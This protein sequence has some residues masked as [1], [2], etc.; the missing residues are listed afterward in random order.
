MLGS[1][2]RIHIAGVGMTDDEKWVILQREVG[3]K[4]K[5]ELLDALLLATG[6]GEYIAEAI[7]S[8]E[9]QMHDDA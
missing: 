2:T 5:K 6:L 4:A 3:R 1:L 8:H 9:R 7:E